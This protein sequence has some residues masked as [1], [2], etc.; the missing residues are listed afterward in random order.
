M[1]SLCFTRQDSLILQLW[2]RQSLLLTF[3]PR[4]KHV[5]FPHPLLQFL[6]K[7]CS[8]HSLRFPDVIFIHLVSQPFIWVDSLIYWPIGARNCWTNDC[9]I[10]L[11]ISLIQWLI[12]LLSHWFIALLHLYNCWISGSL[13][14]WFCDSLISWYTC[15][16]FFWSTDSLFI[17]ILDSFF[18][19]VSFSEL[20]MD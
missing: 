1:Y 3:P 14:H 7:D 8:W 18:H 5:V 20:C 2:F 16:C 15:Y 12:E 13:V 6:W 9:W 17:W 4:C 10:G 19:L 11:L